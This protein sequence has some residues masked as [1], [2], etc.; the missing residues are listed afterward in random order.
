M[1]SAEITAYTVQTGRLGQLGTEKF[2]VLRHQAHAE[3][4]GTTEADSNI[5]FAD[6]FADSSHGYVTVGTDEQVTAYLPEAEYPHWIDLLRYEDPMFLHWTLA[7]V[8]GEADPDGII[9]LA[10][11]PEPPGE[12]PIDLTP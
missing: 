9:H 12:G 5:Y 8:P 2:I 6:R 11:G 7:E 10:T 4:G 3:G 1:P